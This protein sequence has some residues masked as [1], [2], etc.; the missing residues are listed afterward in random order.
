MRI[1]VAGSSKEITRVERVIASLREAGHVISHDWP[2]RMRAMGLD[3]TALV[4]SDLVEE[5]RCDLHIGIDTADVFL[6]LAP[7]RPTTGAWV[8]LG[9][10]AGLRHA[11]TVTPRKSIKPGIICAGEHPAW[12]E[13]IICSH[14]ETDEEAVEHLGPAADWRNPHGP[15]C[16][17]C[18]K[19]RA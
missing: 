8:E 4:R 9:Y 3:D 13:A 14:F 16:A 15:G 5:L 19:E 2:A 6:L 1:Y 11:S 7:T 12:A 10:A 18:A 17:C